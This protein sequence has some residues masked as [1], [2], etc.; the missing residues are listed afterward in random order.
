MGLISAMSNRELPAVPR[1]LMVA[2]GLLEKGWTQRDFARDASG[3]SC[4]IAS[5]GA[6]RFCMIGAINRAWYDR[7]G[8]TVPHNEGVVISGYFY[9]AEP[10]LLGSIAYWNDRPG[11]TLSEVLA[12]MDKL[13]EISLEKAEVQ[14]AVE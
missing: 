7:T 8:N 11:R 3:C 9:R 2:R 4:G 1:A 12:V 13:I 5:D 6:A 10:S 14:E